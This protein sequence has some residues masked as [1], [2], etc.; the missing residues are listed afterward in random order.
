MTSGDKRVFFIIFDIFTAEDLEMC[1]SL[2]AVWWKECL[3]SWWN[4]KWVNRKSRWDVKNCQMPCLQFFFKSSIAM[5]QKFWH[6]PS[7]FRRL[8]ERTLNFCAGGACTPRTTALW[9]KL[10]FYNGNP[11][12]TVP[13]LKA[14]SSAPQNLQKWLVRFFPLQKYRAYRNL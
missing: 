8:C 3:P 6:R 9:V 5:Q 4:Q 1:R 14:F 2:S 13:G 11:P 10:W 7:W 12:K